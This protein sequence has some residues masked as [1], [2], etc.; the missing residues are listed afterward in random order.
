[1]TIWPPRS[2]HRRPMVAAHPWWSRALRQAR[3]TYW[4]AQRHLIRRM[5][6]S[7][8]EGSFMRNVLTKHNRYRLFLRQAQ[9]KSWNN[10]LANVHDPWGAYYKFLRGSRQ[11][12]L[13]LLS[14][15]QDAP[16]AISPTQFLTQFVWYLQIGRA[17]IR[18]RPRACPHSR[19]GEPLHDWEILTVIQQTSPSKAAGPDGLPPTIFHKCQD[20]PLPFLSTLFGQCLHL[21]QFPQLWKAGDAF[22]LPKAGRISKPICHWKDFR[23]ITLLPAVSKV[24]ERIILNRLIHNDEIKGRAFHL[25]H[26]FRQQR[27]CQTAILNLV[28][29]LQHHMSQGLLTAAVF[30]DIAGAFDTVPHNT[31]NQVLRKAQYPP[32][33]SAVIADYLHDR[34]TRFTMSNATVIAQVTQGTP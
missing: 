32:A 34:R 20:I 2:Q 19:A 28:D 30:F 25:Q 18:L 27:S 24:F 13:P 29:S 5:S 6:L 23:V 21:G 8:P 14:A 12:R 22:L 9:R 11:R 7:T 16:V 33:L 4:K 15:E 1:M 3:H 26:R 17:Q 31:L 10:F